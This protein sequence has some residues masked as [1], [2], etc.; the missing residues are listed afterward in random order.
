MTAIQ[1][2]SDLHLE[3]YKK[4]PT[5]ICNDHFPK[6]PTLFLVGDIGY[7]FD[8]IWLKFIE[9]CESKYEKI[10][11]VQG[12]H[13]SYKNDIDKITDY[14][15]TTL[16]E[17]PK[18]TFLDRGKIAYLDGYKVIGCTLWSEQTINIYSKM[19]DSQYIY[20]NG[21]YLSLYDL[22]DMHKEDKKWLDGN[23]DENT[24][25][26]T[27]HLP[28][29]DLIHPKYK[30]PFYKDYHSAYAS[31]CNSIVLKAKIWIYGHTHI[32]SD[33]MFENKVRCICN[34]YAYPDE[35][36]KHFTNKVFYL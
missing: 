28:S 24:I 27:H 10:F 15:R 35:S 4:L 26:I 18:F 19:N 5:N 12:N 22:L 33:V 20:K 7:P 11:Y 25:V 6:A 23:V 13:E 3:F 31:D 1:I 2:L 21:S 32:G 29:Y 30:I 36:H 8:D 34:P 9:W 17:K 16:N 14:I